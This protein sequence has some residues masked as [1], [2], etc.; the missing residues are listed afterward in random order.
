MGVAIGR[1]VECVRPDF[2]RDI[3]GRAEAMLMQRYD[4]DALRA[5]D[6]CCYRCEGPVPAR[7]CATTRCGKFATTR[8]P[9][10]RRL[11]GAWRPLGGA[12]G[13]AS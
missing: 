5:F 11:E 6:A 9:A 1:V 7:D 4:I 8:S 12:Y 10:V 2:S 3:I 13:V